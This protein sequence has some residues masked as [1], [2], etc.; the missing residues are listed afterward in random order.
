[1]CPTL[2]SAPKAEVFTQ[3]RGGFGFTWTS[4]DIPVDAQHEKCPLYG[5][6]FVD[7][8][9]HILTI[10]GLLFPQHNNQ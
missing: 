9:R 2:E 10:C 1:M 5:G 6:S 4:L 3:C 7:T 8:P